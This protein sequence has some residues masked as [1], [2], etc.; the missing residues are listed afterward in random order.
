MRLL[1]TA[2][3]WK[4]VTMRKGRKKSMMTTNA[5]LECTGRGCVNSL[6]VGT[7]GERITSGQ[8]G[9]CR[10]SE[11]ICA[12]LSFLQGDA[13][14]WA[15][16][17]MEVFEE[18]HVPFNSHWETF[19][20]QFKAHFEAADEAV[21]DK[22]KLRVLWQD[23][24]T[25]PEYAAQFKQLMTRTGYSPA[26]LR[27]CFYEHLAPRIKDELVH[28]ARPI[29]TL[30]ELISVGSDI[31]VQV[32]QRCAEKE[33]ERRRTGAS[34]GTTTTPAPVTAKPFAAPTADP[35]VMDIDATQTRENFLRQMKGKCF[36]CGSTTHT[37]RE[38]NH[39]RDLCVY[40]RRVGHQEAVCMDKFLCNPKGQ[41]A[42]ATVGIYDSDAELSVGSS[43]ESEEG[44]TAT[45]TLVQLR[46]KQKVLEAQI[47]MLEEGDF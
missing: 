6:L 5:L 34:T 42:A 12:V 26:D 46:E 13:A 47:T 8:S 21:D 29:G 27:D 9:D 41:K 10:D 45:T 3:T 14:V 7:C 24:S 4:M 38:G 19:R 25:V 20:E 40:C 15:V 31:D 36:G 17:A 33:H 18:G 11:W 44:V 30:D 37:Q 39:E 35:T 32:R 2:M 43:G 23:D 1:T 22:E 16:P 28:T